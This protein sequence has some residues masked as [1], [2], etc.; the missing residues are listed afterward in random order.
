MFCPQCKSEYKEGVFVCADCGASLV[1]Q[2]PKE[3]KGK[4]LEFVCIIE[5]TF[6]AEIAMIESILEG[7]DVDYYIQGGNIITMSP[8]ADPVRVL[9][10]KEHVGRAKELLKDLD[11]SCTAS[12][13]G[14][15]EEPDTEDKQ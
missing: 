6:S 11:L 8:Y 2:L 12:F 3:N 4:D 9:V 14:D 7:S 5:T 13:R 15:N 1:P 10:V